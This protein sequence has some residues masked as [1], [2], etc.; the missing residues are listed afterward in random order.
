M[1]ARVNA[2]LIAA[3]ELLPGFV[4]CGMRLWRG[5]IVDAVLALNLAGVLAALEI[6]LLGESESQSSFYDLALVLAALA[7]GSGLVFVR[8]LGHWL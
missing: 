4:A 2:W 6:M 1:E 3:L 8:Y 7:L 5:T